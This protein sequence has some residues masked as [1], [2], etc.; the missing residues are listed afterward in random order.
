MCIVVGMAHTYTTASP[1]RQ[2]VSTGDR[3]FNYYD[4]EAGTIGEDAGQDGWF[5]FHADGGKRTLLN[6]ERICSLAY[7]ARKGWV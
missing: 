5:T 7:A 1:D 6:G 3:V 4:M 2:Q